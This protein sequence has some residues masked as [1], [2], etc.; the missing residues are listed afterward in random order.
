[1]FAAEH[2]VSKTGAHISP[3]SSLANAATNIQAA[4]NVASSGDTVFVNDGT[5]YPSIDIMIT[6]D[7]TVKS[8]NGAEKTIIDGNNTNRCF[9]SEHVNPIIDGF[10]ITNGYTPN[11]GGGIYIEG[12]FLQNCLIAGNLCSYQ[13]GGIYCY[14]T[15]IRNCTITEN[16]VE[17]SGGGVHCNDG[18]VTNCMITK[19]YAL[20]DGGGVYSS[21]GNVVDCVI[22]GNTA[23]DDGGGGISSMRST[24]KNCTLIG[25]STKYDGGGI[26]F[27][28]SI[29]ENCIVSNNVA[30]GNL[31]NGGGIDGFRGLIRNCLI[32]ENYAKY[33]GGGIHIEGCDADNCTI[34][35]N[36]ANRNGDG[37][38]CR[39]GMIQ[40]S[41]LWNNTNDCYFYYGSTNRY[42]CIESWTNI[43]SGIITNNPEFANA[44]AGNYRL[45]FSS[46]CINSGTNMDWMIS[47]TDLDDNPR[48]IGTTVDMGAYEFVPE[49]CFYLSF[50]IYNL[51]IVNRRR[52][53]LLR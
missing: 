13:G 1:M 40:N 52:F 6:N 24:V 29:V 18:V 20:D 43:V 46:P 3:F 7:I 34:I 26:V 16:T 48:I 32:T 9:Y 35:A 8:I 21:D 10:T 39:N 25:N 19:N 49:P 30:T 51:L 28:R 38:Y 17:G 44:D 37:I 22:I 41:I 15:I 42:N 2:Y 31:S 4:V 47:A 23:D 50:I 5:Y 45:L 11:Y 36:S 27:S 33:D 14:E 12:G 53:I